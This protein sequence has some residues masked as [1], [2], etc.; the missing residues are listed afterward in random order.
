MQSKR[1]V[2]IS[3]FLSYHLRH[4]PEKLGLVLEKGGWISTIKLLESAKNNQ[5]SLTFYELEEVVTRN[6][7]QRF[8]FN[9]SRTKIRANQGH[10]IAIDSQLE[11]I[12]PPSILY[13]GTYQKVTQKIL[14][15][16]LKKMSRH[17]VHLSTTKETAFRVGSRRG[18]PVIFTINAQQ[19]AED[20]FIF[21]CSDNGVWLVDNVPPNYL[22]Q[23]SLID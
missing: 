13:H 8:S 9:E 5:F 15:E 1:L 23:D 21:Y 18:K 12:I 20:G 4:A 3:R 17:H 6:D 16:G 22:N 19:M 14:K 10:S 7:K 2:K 11:P